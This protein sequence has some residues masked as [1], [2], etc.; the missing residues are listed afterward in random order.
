MQIE[1]YAHTTAALEAQVKK[2]ERERWEEQLK[3]GNNNNNNGP[4]C[5]M[6]EENILLY[7]FV[8]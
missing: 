4:Q 7:Y 8:Y 1:R 2:V 5:H 3:P 6:G